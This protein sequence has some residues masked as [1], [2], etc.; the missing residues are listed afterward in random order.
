MRIKHRCP[1][2]EFTDQTDGSV[3]RFAGERFVVTYSFTDASGQRW[4]N[5]GDGPER[6]EPEV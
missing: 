2:H 4:R 1:L 6:I 5:A 3:V